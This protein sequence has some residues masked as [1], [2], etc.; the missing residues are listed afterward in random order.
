[1]N[2]ALVDGIRGRVLLF[3][4]WLCVFFFLLLLVPSLSLQ[5]K[6]KKLDVTMSMEFAV[7]ST[8]SCNFQKWSGRLLDDALLD[9]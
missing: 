1:M 7:D 8:E 3:G 2:V 6:K 4:T 5:V 9:Y